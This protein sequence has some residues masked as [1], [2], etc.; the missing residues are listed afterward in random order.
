[1]KGAEFKARQGWLPFVDAAGIV[2]EVLEP[3]K[4]AAWDWFK[5]WR[6]AFR[7]K[8][9]NVKAAPVQLGLFFWAGMENLQLFADE[10]GTV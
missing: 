1:M 3:V 2:L 8:P 5:A 10:L 6:K 7:S 4:A 9:V